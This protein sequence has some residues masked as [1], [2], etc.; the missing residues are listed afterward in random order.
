MLKA[1]T[2]RLVYCIGLFALTACAVLPVPVVETSM[3]VV[4]SAP[5]SAEDRLAQSIRA[6]IELEAALPAHHSDLAAAV[7]TEDAL[8]SLAFADD[9]ATA[10]AELIAALADE[11]SSAL[12]ERTRFASNPGADKASGARMEKVISGLIGAINAEVHRNQV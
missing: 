4:T 3:A 2:S 10:R 5:L 12:A 6:R 1:S 7:A 11:L 8:R 9:P